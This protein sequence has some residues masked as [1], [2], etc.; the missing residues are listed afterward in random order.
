M[1]KVILLLCTMFLS[2]STFSQ[3]EGIGLGVI[4]GEPTGLSAKMWTGDHTAVDAALAWSLVGNGY[5]HLHADMLMHSFAIEVDQGQ[6]PV[7][8][9]IGAKL[10]LA[11][12]LGLGVRIPF[13]M[14]YLFE[15]ASID[16]F[17]EL[18]PILNLIPATTFSFEGGIGIRYFF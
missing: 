11:S 8:F 6:L 1:K 18:V 15:S 7:Y 4:I 10:D 16:V 3:G 17:V 9:G 2:L 12:N 5:I 13:G 14:A